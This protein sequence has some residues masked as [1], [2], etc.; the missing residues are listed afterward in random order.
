MPGL[1]NNNSFVFKC[2]KG[3]VGALVIGIIAAVAILA[4]ANF[5]SALIYLLIA[6]AALLIAITLCTTAASAC[7]ST[8]GYIPIVTSARTPWWGYNNFCNGFGLFRH[9][10]IFD[11]HGCKSNNIHG[12]EGF[13]RSGEHH[14]GRP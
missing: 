14:H 12:H 1:N 11:F 7:R 3:F 8:S 6:A 10:P 13:R 4:I 5:F 9:Q 2:L